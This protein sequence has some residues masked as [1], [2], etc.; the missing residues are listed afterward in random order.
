MVPPAKGEVKCL[1]NSHCITNSGLNP[2]PDLIG[3]EEGGCDS[4]RLRVNSSFR[5]KNCALIF[6]FSNGRVQETNGNPK[7]RAILN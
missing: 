4:G 1:L 7:V 3:S 6:G 2:P 5:N